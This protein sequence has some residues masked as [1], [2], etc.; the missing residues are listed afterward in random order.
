VAERY[1]ELCLR[2][3]RHVDGLVDAYYGPADIKAHGQEGEASDHLRWS[4]CGAA[5]P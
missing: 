2:L 1:L 5:H 4:Q 3:G